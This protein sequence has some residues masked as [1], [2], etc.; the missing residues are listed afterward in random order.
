LKQDSFLSNLRVCTSG[1]PKSEPV[2]ES[3]NVQKVN[4]T[5]NVLSAIESTGPQKLK[6]LGLEISETNAL[7]FGKYAT[8]P[9]RHFVLKSALKTD[10]RTAVRFA[11]K[12]NS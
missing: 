10:E 2:D 8:V 9:E 11:I 5:G 4:E 1:E 3:Q 7:S 12:S 6:G